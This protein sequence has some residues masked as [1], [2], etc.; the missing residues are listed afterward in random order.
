MLATIFKFKNSIP[1][2]RYI[3]MNIEKNIENTTDNV[4][5]HI[6]VMVEE[7]LNYL[8]LKDGE[9]MLDMTFGAGGHSKKILEKFPNVRLICLDRD[10]I[11]Y[12]YAKELSE[13]H[14]KVLPLLG[15]FSDLPELL[16][17]HSIRQKSVDSILFD[18]GCSSMQFDEADRGFSVSKN[19]PLD[20]RMDG[21]R[22]PGIYI[23]MFIFNSKL[24]GFYLFIYLN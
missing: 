1:L 16:N 10:I 15:K 18:F 13:K 3:C 9:T 19:G 24:N 23:Y 21:N 4:A 2:T 6:P 8:K 17:T 14:P 11:A 22:N 5:P 20:M 12:N 7:S